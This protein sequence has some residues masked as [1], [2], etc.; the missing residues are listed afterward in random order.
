MKIAG[1]VGAGLIGRAVA[2][3]RARAACAVGTRVR[4]RRPDRAAR[5]GSRMVG[6]RG[7]AAR[8][9][10]GRS[11]CAAQAEYVQE[12][13]PEKVEV[14]RETFARLDA[15]AR[16]ERSSL[17]RPP[18]IVPSKFTETLADARAASSPTR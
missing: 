3:F 18:P 11:R 12:S 2:Q 10:R 4:T 6:S 17:P 8:D 15:A 14:K 1:I 13:G 5:S 7:A 9:A 16:K